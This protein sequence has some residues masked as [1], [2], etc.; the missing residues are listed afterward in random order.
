MRYR[1]VAVAHV[2]DTPSNWGLLNN[3][4]YQVVRSLD[5]LRQERSRQLSAAS[6]DAIRSMVDTPEAHTLVDG[7]A[8]PFR[9]T[10]MHYGPD[11]RIDLT[12]IDLQAPLYGLVMTC[13]P[14]HDDLSLGAVMTAHI[15][16]TAQV[17]N[18]WA[19]LQ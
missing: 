4:L 6:I 13:F 10:L 2:I 15:T 14:G 3:A 11:T 8:R 12:T 5:I 19:R 18:D 16:H 1:K 7:S 17:L 9:N